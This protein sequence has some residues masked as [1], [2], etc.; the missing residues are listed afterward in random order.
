MDGCI[1]LLFSI[2]VTISGNNQE[3]RYCVLL[4]WYYFSDSVTKKKKIDKSYGKILGKIFVFHKINLFQRGYPWQ[5]SMSVLPFPE[6]Y[7]WFS[8]HV[9]HENGPLF[10]VFLVSNV[11]ETHIG[12]RKQ[13]KHFENQRAIRGDHGKWPLQTDH[14]RIYAAR[15]V[16][17]KQ[18]TV[19]TLGESDGNKGRPW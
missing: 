3:R 13:W 11:K 8:A 6:F 17:R 15:N 10:P 2:S 1:P 16:S 5:K 14:E 12:N 18:N 4:F 7:E 9:S 19:E